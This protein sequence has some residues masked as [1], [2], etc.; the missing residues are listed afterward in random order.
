[1]YCRY[2]KKT[3]FSDTPYCP[4]CGARLDNSTRSAPN[5]QPSAGIAVMSFFLPLVGFIYYLVNARIMPRRAGSAAKGA[6]T[7]FTVLT[8][9]LCAWLAVLHLPKIWHRLDDTGAAESRLTEFVPEYPTY[10]GGGEE[11]KTGSAS[12]GT[13]SSQKPESKPTQSEA[14]SQRTESADDSQKDNNTDS[15]EKDAEITIGDFITT[16]NY[17]FA[18]TELVVTVRNK[19]D[20]LCDFFV[21]IEAVDADGYRLTTD[22]VLAQSLRPGQAT[23]VSAFRYVEQSKLTQFQ[24]ATYHVLKVEKFD[25]AA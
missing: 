16:Y 24:N 1:M 4:S 18:E 11:S 8:A 22:M 17:S 15:W 9:A 2:C 5:D 10:F 20:K 21:T 7:G 13:A 14:A 6:M 19:T 3:V 25:A 12:S 23:R